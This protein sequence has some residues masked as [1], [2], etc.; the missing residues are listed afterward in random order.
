MSL[1]LLRSLANTVVVPIALLAASTLQGYG[2]ILHWCLWFG[3]MAA[4]VA[5]VF[6]AG[7]WCLVGCSLRYAMPAGFALSIF[8][9]S[10]SIL[11]LPAVRPIG[12]GEIVGMIFAVVFAPMMML[13]LMGRRS[14]AG[15]LSA[16]FPL[17]NGV[18]C[19]ADGGN[20]AIINHHFPAVYAR[21]AVD[22]V[23]LDRLGFRARGLAPRALTK[24]FVFGDTVYSPITGTVVK[25]FDGNLD[26][27]PPREDRRNP[28]GN[29]VMVKHTPSGALVL[30]A[31]LQQSS[32][33]VKEG[34]SVSE[35]DPI[36]RVGNSGIS[37]EPH[38]HISC[39]IDDVEEYNVEGTGIPLLF[40]G[41][42]M[43]RNTVIKVQ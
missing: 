3:G 41:R 10:I 26:M 8:Y 21:Y 22:I 16:A 19:V 33:L 20:N 25:A 15:G 1:D 32:V 31:H 39:E 11:A 18:Y 42:F 7:D 35:G 36:A 5:Y 38:L 4:Y 34:D 23:K 6:L 17:R 27:E 14:P 30:L 37:T 24:Y 13:A 2:S 29:Y 43:S 28:A 12:K 40:C 9:S